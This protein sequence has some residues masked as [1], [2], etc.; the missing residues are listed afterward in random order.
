MS[1]G[2]AKGE[3]LQLIKSICHMRL[4]GQSSENIASILGESEDEI[5]DICNAMDNLNISDCSEDSVNRIYD[6][7]QSGKFAK[8]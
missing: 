3:R 7:L 4:N 5:G 6:E 1:A 2:K 8:A